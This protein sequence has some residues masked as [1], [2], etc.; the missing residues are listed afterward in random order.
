MVS[1]EDSLVNMTRQSNNSSVG[2]VGAQGTVGTQDRV[3]YLV[4]MVQ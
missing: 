3:S 4:E 1:T 2:T